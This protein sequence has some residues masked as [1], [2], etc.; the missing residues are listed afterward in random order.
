MTKSKYIPL[1]LP[2]QDVYFEQLMYPEDPIYNIGAKITI[3]GYVNYEILDKAYRHLITQHDAYRSII[4]QFEEEVNIEILEDHDTSLSFIDFSEEEDANNKA[5]AFMQQTF[6]EPF[7]FGDKEM[8][9]KFILVKVSSTYYYLFSVYHHII[10][11]G[12]GTS[13]MFQRLVRNY[14]ELIE[15]QVVLSE[16]PYSYLDFIKDDQVYETSKAYQKDKNYWKE[17]FNNIPEA[18]LEKSCKANKE[19]KSSR[20]ELYLKR[21]LYNQLE[22][23]GKANGCSTFHVILGILYLY[24]GRKH[25][26]YDFAIGV[27]VLNRGKSIFKKTVGLFMGLAPL[28]IQF[29]QEYSFETLIKKIKQELRKDYRHQRFPLGRL[30]KELNIFQEKDRVFNMTLSYEKQDYAD[31]FMHTKTE[32][33]PLSHESERVALAVYIR[34]FDKEEDVKIDFDYNLNYFDEV[35][36]EKVVTHIEKLIPRVIENTQ[37][38][39]HRYEYLTNKE[40]IQLL[41]EFNSTKTPYDTSRTIIEAFKTNVL[42]TPDKIAI[43][44]N[45]KTLTYKE[46]DE[47][48]NRIANQIHLHPK[49]DNQEPIAVLMDRSVALIVSLLGVLKSGRAFIPLDPSFPK[50]RLI[51]ICNHSEVKLIIGDKGLKYAFENITDYISYEDSV[52]NESQHHINTKIDSQTTAYIIYTSGS[53]GKPKGVAISHRSLYNFIESM[54]DMPGI[55]KSDT[56]FSVTTPSFDI[57]LL[58]FFVPLV[59]GAKVY[60]A[61]KTTLNDPFAVLEEIGK[62]KPSIIQATPSFFQM[63]YN[64]GW[65]GDKRLKAL[66]G[67]DALSNDLAQKMLTT[68]AGLWNMYG[69]TETTIWS[70]CK[71]I[72][73]ADEASI[74]GKPIQNTQ[75]YILDENFMLLPIGVSGNIFIGGDGVAQEYYKN[76][77]LTKERFIASPFDKN[78]RLYNTGDIGKWNENG[79]IE[80]LGRNDHQVKIRGYR[81][82]LGEIE[83][84]LNELNAI[85]KAIV[86]AQKK[87]DQEAYLVAYL[88]IEKD[89]I[90]EQEII[91]KLRQELPEYMVP[92][93]L[94]EIDEFPLTPNKKIDRKTLTT[95][96]VAI[97]NETQNFVAPKSFLEKHLSNSFKTVLKIDKSISIQE[98][99]FVLG[100][101]S[102]NAVKLINTIKNNLQ[103]KITLK[104]IFDNPTVQELAQFLEDKEKAKLINTIRKADQQESYPITPSQYSIW[105]ASQQVSK[106]IAYNMPAIF[107]M[108]GEIDIEKLK[109]TGGFILNKYEI[110]RTNFIEIEGIPKQTIKAIS[111]IDIDIFKTNTITSIEEYIN[112]PFDLEKDV[113]IRLAVF[114]RENESYMVFCTH[115]CIMDGWSLELLIQEFIKIYKGEETIV[116]END[117]QFKDYAV[118]YDKELSQNELRFKTFWSEYLKEY[119]WKTLIRQDNEFLAETHEGNTAVYYFD[120]ITYEAIESFIQKQQISLHTLLVAAFNIVIYK[121]YEHKD[122]C[123]GT[124]NSGRDELEWQNQLGMFVK[125]LPY[126]TIIDSILDVNEFL[127]QTHQGLLTIDKYQDIPQEIQQT[128]RLDALLVLQNPSFSYEEVKM[129]EEL[130]LILELSKVAYNRIPL[131]MNFSV[132]N[133][134]MKTEITYSTSYDETTIVLVVKQLERVIEEFIKKPQ[135]T[136]A[137]ITLDIEESSTLEIDFDF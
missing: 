58:E 23:I 61:D 107:K 40:K 11:D 105:I 130:S 90:S 83:T 62:I 86:I 136:L 127:A 102:L 87:Q 27:P 36:I 18:L 94:V 110:L 88:I 91:K 15:A 59:S 122:I 67:G 55:A 9:H 50:E 69:P 24:F 99:F 116:K 64:A 29:D 82:E 101:H 77:K 72:K 79:E 73:K 109:K 37:E 14:N 45:T 135:Q 53:T 44:D 85:K 70:S 63:L 78:Q 80:F 4:H 16:Y 20:R 43:E 12:W 129:D 13:L 17:K 22:T 28:R 112:K 126:R 121:I 6:K 2:Q 128:L 60:L 118:W 41:E 3:E 31:H 75:I 8:L 49:N 103:Y 137:T 84:K 134:K 56:L 19:N 10:T 111:K 98:S 108:V 95:R 106:S 100:G 132:N 104:D 30:I 51:Y 113:L 32:V 81:I 35:S 92:H 124:V 66:C 7:R 115:H 65:S 114:K 39:I 119:Q 38:P 33:I 123:I 25:Q 21:K 133:K 89:S 57:S 96:E 125:T 42:L 131:L 54:K 93:V 76:S 34:E 74:I 68:T 52:A 48:S 117:L 97:Q 1:T 47:L 71:E 26:N 120:T 5:I 46:V